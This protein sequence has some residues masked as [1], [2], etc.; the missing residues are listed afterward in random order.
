M[1]RGDGQPGKQVQER[2]AR[3]RPHQLV[4][5]Q[6]APVAGPGGK[7]QGLLVIDVEILGG[8]A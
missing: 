7:K 5:V 2:H 8:L 3:H 4:Q 6:P 1:I